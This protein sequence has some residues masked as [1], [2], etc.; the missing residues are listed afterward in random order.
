MLGLRGGRMADVNTCRVFLFFT[1][2]FFHEAQGCACER[3]AMPRYGLCWDLCRY[4]K[5]PLGSLMS[6]GRTREQLL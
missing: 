1:F 3:L 5:K 6:L 4:L 2:F